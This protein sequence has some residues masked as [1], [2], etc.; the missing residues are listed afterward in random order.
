MTIFDITER[1]QAEEALRQQA[2]VRTPANTELQR[3]IAER[4]Q[5]AE[6]LRIGTGI[7]AKQLEGIVERFQQADNSTAWKYG[8]TGLGLA[9]S[10]VLCR[11]LGY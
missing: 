11:L 8:G 2:E 10:R 6:A 9:I 5:A 7:P 1:K 4:Q 3:G